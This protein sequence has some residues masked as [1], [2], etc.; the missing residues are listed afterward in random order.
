MAAPITPY[1]TTVTFNGVVVGGTAGVHNIKNIRVSGITRGELETTHMGSTIGAKTYEPE[2]FYDAGE[3]TIDGDF[4]VAAANLMNLI[5]TAGATPTPVTGDL[6]I[7]FFDAG[8][9]VGP[10][11][12]TWANTFI[13]SAELSAPYNGFVTGSIT[14]KLCAAPAFA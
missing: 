1:G 14:F 11:Q 3:V 8:V 4:D 5:R 13:K 12:Y 2:P 6:V 10:P 9:D 7:N